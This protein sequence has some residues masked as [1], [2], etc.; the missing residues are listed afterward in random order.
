MLGLGT[1]IGPAELRAHWRAPAGLAIGFVSQFVWMPL[2]AFSL[3]VALGLERRAA[4]GLVLVGSSPGGSTSNLFAYWVG[5]DV[6]L[7]VSMT[8][9]SNV[10]ALFMMPLSLAVYARRFVGSGL[11]VPFAQIAV[12]LTGV[13]VPVLLGMLLRARRP[14]AAALVERGAGV[15]GSVTI[16]LAVALSCVAYL[17]V[18]VRAPPATVAAA[19]LLPAFGFA[20][21]LGTAA[22]ARRPAPQVRA[23]CLETG[24]QNGLLALAVVTLSFPDR[25]ADS[26]AILVPVLLYTNFITILSTALAA[27]LVIHAR[28][29]AKPHAHAGSQQQQQRALPAAAAKASADPGTAADSVPLVSVAVDERR[30]SDP[31]APSADQ[32]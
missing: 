25:S 23:I 1:C 26:D 28:R 15:L 7:S 27:A 8:V 21:G 11:A 24:I 3:S 29:A 22:L 32:V 30:G 31:P 6:A 9:F 2:I 19:L 4:V 12:S 16:A 18:L 17:P 10:C 13:C 20:F 5:A 14:R